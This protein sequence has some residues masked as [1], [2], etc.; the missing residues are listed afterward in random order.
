MSDHQA[1]AD[2]AEQALAFC[3]ASIGDWT[4]RAVRMLAETPELA[5][6]DFMT[7]VV[8]GDEAR[9]RDAITRDPAVATRPDTG[10]GW[11][12]LHVA[13]ASRWHRLDP[14]RAPGLVEVARLLLDAG[15]DPAA[16]TR[17]PRADWTPLR[18][19]VAGAANA[20]IVRLLLERGAVP[21]DHDLYLACFGD[22]DRE[23]LRLLLGHAPGI[24]ETT[25]LSAP[26][27]VSDTEAVRALLDAGADPNRPL[28]AGLFGESHEG[29]PPWPTVWAAV[30][31]DCPVE[32]TELLLI[33]GADPDAAG[34]DGR[35]PYRL[36]TT[37]G[38]AGL[39]GLLRRYGARDDTTAAE[40]FL[41]ACLRGD[42]AA[43]RGLAADDPGLAARLTDA[44]RGDAIVLAADRGDTATVELMLDLGFPAGTRGGDN[45]GT[46]L[47]A[48]A[49]AGSAETVRLL[50]ARGADIEARDTTWDSTPLD[51]AKV[52]SGQRQRSGSRPDW[53]ATVR[54]L[55]EAGAST[56]TLVVSPDDLK[57]ASP[58][59]ADLLRAAG[60]P[61]RR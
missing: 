2:L 24:A 27:S 19:A 38:R 57:P 10:T 47:H 55:L 50:L 34:P 12:P 21:D 60:V 46:A 6:A 53:V 54:I 36:A 30:R 22:D 61:E 26:I 31:S 5:S 25:A 43:A 39:A 20:D 23:S 16:R 40:R 37:Q 42:Q 15:A 44:E 51:W 41:S 59:V 11:T 56:E 58:E 18:C 3:V 48:A 9:V 7:A 52:G 8:L 13:C 28:P 45:G 49:Y 17:G 29:E 4:G 32:L 35:S 33:D 14:A 1:P